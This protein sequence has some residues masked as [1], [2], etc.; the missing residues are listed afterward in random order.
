MCTDQPSEVYTEYGGIISTGQQLYDDNTLT[1]PLTGSDYIAE[2][3]GGA[4]IYNLNSVT[5]VIG[6]TTGSTC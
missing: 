3:F 1:S 6:T 4:N 2:N 5:G